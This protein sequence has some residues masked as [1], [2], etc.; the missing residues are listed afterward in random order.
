MCRTDRTRVST[1]KNEQP[2]YGDTA[3]KTIACYITPPRVVML[4]CGIHSISLPNPDLDLVFA[5][6]HM[7]HL[8]YSQCY[9]YFAMLFLQLN[10]LN[11]LGILNDYSRSQSV[12]ISLVF[13]TTL[14]TYSHSQCL[15]RHAWK[16]VSALTS[17]F[18]S[19]KLSKPACGLNTLEGGPKEFAAQPD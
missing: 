6:R 5:A 17:M 12:S 7:V 13:S 18:L 19:S 16:L 14:L 3:A 10:T 8:L 1:Q 15:G 4:F 9:Y 11:V 2:P